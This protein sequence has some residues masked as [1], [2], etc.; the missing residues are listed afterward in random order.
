MDFSEL[1]NDNIDYDIADDETFNDL[2]DSFLDNDDEQTANPIDLNILSALNPSVLSNINQQYTASTSFGDFIQNYFKTSKEFQQ[3]SLINLSLDNSETLITNTQSGIKELYVGN[4]PLR[5]TEMEVTNFFFNLGYKDIYQFIMKKNQ[6]YTWYGFAKFHSSK[7]PE[8]VLFDFQE[9]SSKFIFQNSQLRI[10]TPHSPKKSSI[11]PV[12]NDDERTLEY[13]IENIRFGTLITASAIKNIVDMNRE[14]IL[15]DC[16]CIDSSLLS[17]ND[18]QKLCY[19]EIDQKAKKISIVIKRSSVSCVAQTLHEIHEIRFEWN[20]RAL[21]HDRISPVF[22]CN[23]HQLNEK[24]K[25]IVDPYVFLLLEIR[26]PPIIIH[27]KHFPLTLRRDETRLPGSLLIGQSNAWLFQIK[28]SNMQ[29]LVYNDLINHYSNMFRYLSRHNLCPSKFTQNNIKYLV[30]SQEASERLK[31][32]ILL[33][34][35]NWINDHKILFNN[36]INIRWP[37][38][39]FEIKFELMKL[40]S[41]H[42]ITAHDLVVDENLL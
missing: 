37:K 28:G 39:S 38:F 13:P 4:I 20:F 9:N 40:I 18:N 25:R 15:C 30:S 33:S 34:N 42:L 10:S 32:V 1:L 23:I 19:F 2:F 8:D 12:E 35:E 41:K 16:G 24:Y 22:M 7:T 14:N 27:V 31:K 26:R 6:R 29:G 11:L 3:Q 5:S 17:Q 36:F 21:K